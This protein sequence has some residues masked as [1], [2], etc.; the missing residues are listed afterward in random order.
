MAAHIETGDYM[1]IDLVALAS[2]IR[3]VIAELRHWQPMGSELTMKIRSSAT[4][5]GA[6]PLPAPVN[7]NEP[8]ASSSSASTASVPM[9]AADDA[10]A[11]VEELTALKAWDP[12]S[13]VPFDRLRAHVSTV[14]ALLARG[15]VDAH[16]DEFGFL[17]VALSRAK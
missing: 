12:A 17:M 14:D 9:P 7:R 4:S 15:V 5:T 6:L 16:Q 2:K 1:E 8:S 10:R 11:L 3:E 13:A